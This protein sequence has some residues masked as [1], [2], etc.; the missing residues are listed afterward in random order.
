MRPVIT[1]SLNGNSYQL[2]QDGY[3][4]LKAY[5][6][7]AEARLAA[8][9]DKAEILADLEQAIAE[10]CG[11]FLSPHKSVVTGAEVE[12]VIREMGPVD[13][14]AGETS[15]AEQGAGGAKASP[16]T[17]SSP[18]AGPSDP[19]K[20][21][22]APEK[23]LY[24]IHEGA[25]IGGVCT[26]LA[27]FFD[28]DVTVV[29]VIFVLAAI[30]TWGLG[31]LAY[32]LLMFIV[33]YARTSEQHAAAHGWAFNAEELID[34]AKQHYAEFKDGRHWRWQWR[35]QRRAFKWQQR[36]WR[37]EARYRRRWQ[38]L[39]TPPPGWDGAA[40]HVGYASHVLGGLLTA[41]VALF[42]G[43][44]FVALVFAI[45]SLVTTHAVLGWALPA[46]VPLWGAIVFL[47][48]VYWIVVSPFH[49]THHAAYHGGP[50][51]N[52][53]SALW[54]AVI[55]A[56]CLVFLAWLA[57]QHWPQVRYFLE[58]IPPALHRLGLG[59]QSPGTPV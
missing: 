56:A 13:G 22:A 57:W 44:L 41:I 37:A 58:Q 10:K 7:T 25:M 33:P 48:I 34:R 6:A 50:W 12:Q 8:N 52:A 15:S 31:V 30:V 53:W 26:G 3:E 35:E 42:G 45:V 11:R 1:I 14:S 36:A 29:R 19:A 59:G 23:R 54:G 47:V 17:Q 55:W 38:T 39:N 2:E 27:A 40:S 51:G 20:G 49:L 4:A 32:L 28:I 18:G 16:G 24:R 5:L 21:P 43:L 46:H 9:P